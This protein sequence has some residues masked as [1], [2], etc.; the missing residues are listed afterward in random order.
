M[1]KD[2]VFRMTRSYS[3]ISSVSCLDVAKDPFHLL[4]FL[5]PTSLSWDRASDESV[6]EGNV[7]LRDV[8]RWVAW[9]LNHVRGIVSADDGLLSIDGALCVDTWHRLRRGSATVQLVRLATST[10]ERCVGARVVADTDVSGDA[11]A[12]EMAAVS[13]VRMAIKL[14]RTRHL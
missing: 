12:C 8:N 7:S 10:S 2:S 4:A 14:A 9:N 13:C 5:P 1:T 11:I 3:I 6:E